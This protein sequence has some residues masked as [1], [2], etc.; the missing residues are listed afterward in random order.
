VEPSGS[1]FFLPKCLPTNTRKINRINEQP[2]L[3][4]AIKGFSLKNLVGAGLLNLV[5]AKV[6]SGP[7]S[8]SSGSVGRV[9]MARPTFERHV[10]CKTALSLMVII[11]KLFN[12]MN[13]LLPKPNIIQDPRFTP[14]YNARRESGFSLLAIMRFHYVE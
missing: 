7:R 9:T 2:V 13:G 8:N 4:R 3:I 6:N 5:V 10:I 14:R 12:L 11:K 1:I